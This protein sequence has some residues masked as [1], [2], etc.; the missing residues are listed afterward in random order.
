MDEDKFLSEDSQKSK[1]AKKYA[2]RFE[3][4][5]PLVRTVFGEESDRI[6]ASTSG[7]TLPL[8]SASDTGT[9]VNIVVYD[10]FNDGARGKTIGFFSS[11]DY[12]LNGL[13]FTNM[14]IE[15]SNE[16]KYFYIDS[17][18]ALKEFDLSLSTLAHEFQHMIHFGVKS[19]K[20]IKTDSN[21]NEMLSMLC[22]DMVQKHLELDDQDSPKERLR[23]FSTQYYK[24][25][26]RKFENTAL[27]YANAY[28][29]GAWLCRQYGGAELVQ[30][31]MKNSYAGNDCIVEAVNALN[32]TS[33]SF[34]ELFS[35][36]I[37]ACLDDSD[38]TFNQD[39]SQTVSYNAN[40]IT[41]DYPMEA[42]N[43]WGEEYK[44]PAIFKN[45]TVTE[46]SQNYG[47][48]L[49]N[50][51]TLEAGTDSVTLNFASESGMTNTGLITYI[52]IK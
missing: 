43:L 14:T 23:Q 24:S 42:V 1:V 30:T 2:E 25:G 21:F 17:R 46:L 27:S 8:S 22:E 39:A 3:T 45:N 9:K 33:F 16:G 50:Y 41:Y 38:F 48:I 18:F 10:L 47:M 37:M 6:Y 28:A 11:V 34:N 5:Y 19:M 49:K 29:F 32:G 51:E 4:L 44:G 35:H 40:G 12:Y 31:M 36:F 20:G 7:A 13:T 26:I 15:N 52:Y